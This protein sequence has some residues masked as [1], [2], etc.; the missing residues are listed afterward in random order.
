MTRKNQ[1][2]QELMSELYRLRGRVAELEKSL[3]DR[4]G[5]ETLLATQREVAVALNSVTELNDGLKLCV[6]AA[7]SVSDMDCGGVY[8]FDNVTGR[9]ELI[10]HKG[11]SSDFVRCVSSYDEDS[12]NVQIVRAG[13][14]I[15]AQHKDLG[16]VLKEHELKEGLLAMAVVPIRHSGR[17]IGCLN[18]ASHKYEEI[19]FFSRLAIEVI[20]A[21]IGGAIFRLRVQEALRSEK[22]RLQSLVDGLAATGIGVDIVNINYDILWQ[23]S[24]LREKF[25]DSTGKLCYESYMDRTDP[26]VSC[27]MRKAI[28]S[29]RVERLELR[30]V[31]KRDYEL[32]SA[33]LPNPD[34]TVDKAIEVVVDITDMKRAEQDLKKANKE[35]TD[36]LSRVKQTQQQMIEHERL[37]AL[38]QMASGIAHDFNNALMPILGYADLLLSDPKT[39]DDRKATTD[40]LEEIRTAAKDAAAAVSRM[41]EFYRP[42]DGA[43]KISGDLNNVIKMVVDH[44]RPRWQEE[45]EAESAFIEVKTELEDIPPVAADESQLGEA[46]TNLIFN[47]VDAMPEGGLI[48]IRSY[49]RRGRAFLE[50]CDTGCG[51]TE[52]IRR[53]C[54]EPFFS[55]KKG[56]GTGMGLPMVHGIVQRHNG[57]LEIGS[58]PGEGTTFVVGL[59]LAKPVGREKKPPRIHEKPLKPIRILFIDDDELA[60]R[61][62][63]R[64]LMADTHTVETAASGEEGLRKF[65]KGKFDLLIVDRAIPE[66]SGDQ[67]ASEIKARDPEIPVIMLTGFG[68]FMADMGELPPGVDKIVNKPVSLDGLREAL[69]KVMSR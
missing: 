4:K 40:M 18:V 51:M 27:P 43:E 8:L 11:L 46:L 30:A 53:R 36:A 25:G 32:F 24:V 58:V 41:R 19:G 42:S 56:R 63:T 61:V 3:G 67:V 57:T 69:A 15:Y 29:N 7:L 16:V 17:V 33:P 22:D 39:L 26:C 10:F 48:T 5:P 54:L 23:N 62:V 65:R 44:T 60:R 21:Q 37:V 28:A 38:G 49:K 31:D 45:M 2:E 9:L 34:G 66:M 50:I 1:K 12:E 64:C 47:A 52:E 20:A 35:I 55:T 59:Q 68:E 13:R 14:P 6:D